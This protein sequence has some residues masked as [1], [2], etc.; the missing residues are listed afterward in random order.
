MSYS[1]TEHITAAATETTEV[2]RINPPRLRNPHCENQFAV[3]GF[4]GLAILPFLVENISLPFLLFSLLLFTS[5]LQINHTLNFT[6][7]GLRVCRDLATVHSSL[8]TLIGFETRAFWCGNPS[9]QES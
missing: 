8:R 7:T 4:L 1:R 6:S 2:R 3:I 9:N 5:S